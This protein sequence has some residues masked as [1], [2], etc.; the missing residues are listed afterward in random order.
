MA[1]GFRFLGFLC[2]GLRLQGIADKGGK[3]EDEEEEEEE[4][5]EGK[6]SVS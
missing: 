5:E 6:Q 2:V 1:P 4:E 3:G